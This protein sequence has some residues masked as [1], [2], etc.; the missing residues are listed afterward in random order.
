VARS[1]SRK[2][3]AVVTRCLREKGDLEVEVEKLIEKIKGE[4]INDQV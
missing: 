1:I 3:P 4:N 2:D